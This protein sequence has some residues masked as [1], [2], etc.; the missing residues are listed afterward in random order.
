MK[1][2]IIIP[3][4]KVEP[5]I[6]KCLLSCLEQDIAHSDYEIIVVNDG[7]PDNSMTIVERIAAQYDNIHILNQENQG[8]SA[9]RNNGLAIAQGDYIWFVDSDDWIEPRCLARICTQLCDNLDIL[10]L[11]FR[12]TYDDTTLNRDATPTIIEGRASGVE[13]TIRGGVPAPAQFSI[14]RREFLAAKGLSFVR[15][16]YHED[17]EFKPRAIY[18]AESIA[19]DSS[20]A[21]NY[22]QRT[23]GSI[24]SSFNIKRAKDLIF[25][26][27][28][29]D[30]FCHNVVPEARAS[31]NSK[32]ALNF[33]TLLNGFDKLNREEQREVKAMVKGERQIFRAML[34]ADHTKYRIE[35]MCFLLSFSLGLALYGLIRR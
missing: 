6:E 32:I 25:I 14:Y 22:Y 7:T 21:Y 20:V 8:L 16:I 35:G 12:Y 30:D 9:A 27:K 18:L 33:N 19:S 24:T 5:F 3:V 34:N 13:L 4:F 17:S 29:L 2:S 10:Q 23:S 28:S 26:C 1:L 11:Q 15:G 31:I